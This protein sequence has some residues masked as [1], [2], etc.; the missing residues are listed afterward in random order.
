MKSSYFAD[1]RPSFTHIVLTAATV[2]E[3]RA[4]PELVEAGWIELPGT[5]ERLW[6]RTP[7]E[8]G[9]RFHVA[10]AVVRAYATGRW[11]P[12][13]AVA[14]VVGVL[15]Q[16]ER[17]RCA[18]CG[19]TGAVLCEVCHGAGTQ[20]ALDDPADC[21]TC[22][23]EGCY[24][25]ATCNGTCVLPDDDVAVITFQV[26]LVEAGVEV[27]RRRYQ[28]AEDTLGVAENYLTTLRTRQL[29]AARRAP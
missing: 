18:T 26:K 21:T 1:T 5:F 4:R 28:A 12:A 15:F 13:N 29:H 3:D 17:P 6:R 10:L 2:P 27:D 9:V 22:S 25:C 8:H 23:A 11:T 16:R 20:D 14:S 19:G 7:D 24:G